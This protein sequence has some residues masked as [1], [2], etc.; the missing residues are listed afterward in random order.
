MSAANPGTGRRRRRP[1][2][3]VVTTSS[4]H[5]SKPS[6]EIGETR[7]PSASH[8]EV[9]GTGAHR[10]PSDEEVGPIVA[11]NRPGSRYGRSNS[12]PVRPRTPPSGTGINSYT[13]SSPDV[14]TVSPRRQNAL[15]TTWRHS[16]GSDAFNSFL[17]MEEETEESRSRPA[18]AD[19]TKGRQYETAS[20][21]HGVTFD[22]LVNRLV[23]LPMSKQ[24]TRFVAIFLCLYRKFSAPS[25]LLNTLIARFDHTERSSMPQLTRASEQLRL[26]QVIAQ[27]ASDYP[28]DFAYP[29]TRKRLLDFVLAIEK[30][31]VYMFA[32]KEIMLHLENHV[33]DDDIGWP[34]RDGDGDE[35][36][37]SE[38][39][40][41]TSARNSPSAFITQTSFSENLI[42]SISS[43]DLTEDPSESSSRHSGT[44]SHSSSAGRSRTT[45]TQSSSAIAALEDAQ[46][47]ALSLELTPKYSLGKPQWRQF[48]E[49][50]DDEFARELTR[51]DWVMFT[52]FR[53]RDLVRHV[54]LSGQE[55]ETTTSLENVNRMIKEFNHLAFFVASMILLRD[56]PK[57][58][59]RAMEKLMNIALVSAASG[60]GRSQLLTGLS[61]ASSTEQLQ[62]FRRCHRRT[63]RHPR[64]ATDANERT[65][66]P[67]CTKGIHATCHPDG[68]AEESLRLSS[69]LGE[70]VRGTYPI[71]SLAST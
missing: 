5:L 35:Q 41:H 23:A 46:R 26:L 3:E 21:D 30:N 32:A 1:G 19:Q 34:Y 10:V 31:Y 60:Y 62:L 55:K 44:L 6:G 7:G 13:P 52:S 28:G 63:Q 70:F 24:D 29:R 20:S 42:R 66:S 51:I 59:A 68:H 54:S 39:F 47:Q 49:I 58:R 61:E 56:K 8:R 33:A 45:L 53:P 16:A 48:M 14:A 71:P 57:H 18:S 38:T 40:L 22:D 64:S 12:Q 25:R 36:D 15:R 17:D 9:D 27:W 2:S 67:R 4:K 69:G 50:P 43:L 65:D 37:E 11:L